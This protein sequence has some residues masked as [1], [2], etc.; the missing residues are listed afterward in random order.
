MFT[1]IKQGMLVATL[2]AV[3]LSVVFV[4]TAVATPAVS[5]TVS[6]SRVVV[7]GTVTVTDTTSNPDGYTLTYK[8]AKTGYPN[9]DVQAGSPECLNAN[10]SQAQWTYSS[11]RTYEITELVSWPGA[12]D[13]GIS[14]YQTVTVVD[15][16]DA[17]APIILNGPTT[18]SLPTVLEMLSPKTHLDYQ[19][20]Q[21]ALAGSDWESC[22]GNLIGRTGPDSGGLYHYRFEFPMANPGTVELAVSAWTTDSQHADGQTFTLNVTG[23]AYTFGSVHS[24]LY[25]VRLT[26]NG[27]VQ[28]ALN[29]QPIRN[30]YSLYYYA[31]MNSHVAVMLQV[32]RSNRWVTVKHKEA[33]FNIYPQSTGASPWTARYLRVRFGPPNLLGRNRRA[34]YQIKHG[35]KLLKQGH[36][37]TRA[38]TVL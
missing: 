8:W 24:C 36:L 19:C 34:I 12:P 22:G 23:N 13:G 32:R 10:C 16:S 26:A 21:P 33:T 7:G 14:T 28:H 25:P 2:G 30:V 9:Y 11:S 38:C 4:G 1:R 35:R 31:A 20:T 17:P 6:P 5:F 27:Q 18:V 15:P 3:L 29:G 37:S